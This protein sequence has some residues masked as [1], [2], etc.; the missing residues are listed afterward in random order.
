MKLLEKIK[1]FFKRK[2]RLPVDQ[3][4]TI[5]KP[6]KH[7]KIGN[8][9]ITT[10]IPAIE[11]LAKA[12]EEILRKHYLPEPPKVY[13]RKIRN[14]PPPAERHRASISKFMKGKG[15]QSKYY[16]QTIKRSKNI[17][18]EEEEND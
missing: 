7:I 14:T 11:Q 1:N 2:R 15:R 12:Q 18:I 4:K 13:P 8:V 16:R 9:T 6:F 10:D 5:H 17:K 3:E